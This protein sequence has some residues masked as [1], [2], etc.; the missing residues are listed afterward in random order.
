MYVTIYN[1]HPSL[2]CILYSK[3]CLSSFPRQLPTTLEKCS[4][5]CISHPQSLWSS[6]RSQFNK[7]NEMRVIYLPIVEKVNQV[8]RSLATILNIT[9]KINNKFQRGLRLILR[10]MVKKFFPAFTS[11]YL[12]LNVYKPSLTITPPE[13]QGQRLE[14]E[15]LNIKSG[16]STTCF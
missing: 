1:R 10:V 5:L 14:L 4:P 8:H 15:L 7:N 16:E 13:G 2:Y 6:K 9:F 12:N 11:F 3:V